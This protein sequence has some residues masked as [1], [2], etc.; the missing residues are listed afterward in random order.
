MSVRIP[1][2]DGTERV[3]TAEPA[4]AYEAALTQRNEI[5]QQLR[6]VEE[7]RDEV[8]REIARTPGNTDGGQADLTGLK[9]RL[10]ELDAQIVALERLLATANDRVAQLAGIP[11]AVVERPDPPRDRTPE[12]V[13]T[14]IVGTCALLMPVALAWA[15]RIWKQAGQPAMPAVPRELAERLGRMEQAL[16]TV[17]IEVERTSESQ[18][19]L[20]K[21]FTEGGAALGP[22]GA[23]P[24][25]MPAQV[26]VGRDAR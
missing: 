10:A 24:V 9:A 26:A 6:T 21:I 12:M 7:R 3:I 25:E 8:A 17:A 16:D 23:K 1:G 18:R 22:G 13:V 19:Y 14:G 5:R 11:G 4:G 2:P 20:T 15:R